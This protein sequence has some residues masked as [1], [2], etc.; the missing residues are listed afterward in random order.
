MSLYGASLTG[1]LPASWGALKRLKHLYLH[2]N[3]LTGG[4]LL[5][6]FS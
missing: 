1:S 5:G 3:K 4:I 2:N 6:V